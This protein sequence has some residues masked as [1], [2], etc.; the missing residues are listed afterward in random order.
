MK[1]ARL[2]VDIFSN[3]IDAVKTAVVGCKC[4]DDLQ[5]HGKVSLT[6]ELDM[7]DSYHKILFLNYVDL[8]GNAQLVKVVPE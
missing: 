5:F 2:D 1:S 4:R 7:N 6:V 8:E 3:L